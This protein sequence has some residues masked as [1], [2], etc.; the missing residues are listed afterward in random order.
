MRAVGEGRHKWS[1]QLALVYARLMKQSLCQ[2]RQI[3]G[4]C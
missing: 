4:Q 2:P 3:Y 1:V